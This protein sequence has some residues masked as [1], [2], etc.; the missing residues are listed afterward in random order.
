MKGDG[1]VLYGTSEDAV[2]AMKLVFDIYD[3]DDSFGSGKKSPSHKLQVLSTGTDT[4]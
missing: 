4:E 3:A 1:P 2:A